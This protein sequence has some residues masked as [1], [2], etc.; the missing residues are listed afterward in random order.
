MIPLLIQL[1]ASAAGEVLGD[2]IYALLTYNDTSRAV[3]VQYAAGSGGKL[4]LDGYNAE[5]NELFLL[6]NRGGGYVTLSPYHAQSCYITTGAL[7]S[8]LT[9]QSGSSDSAQ[10]QWKVIANSDGTYTFQSKADGRVMDV[11]HGSTDVG[12]RVLSYTKNGFS[13]AQSFRVSCLSTVSGRTAPAIR[14]SVS[15]GYY[16]L[17]LSADRSKCVN[18]QYAS[19]VSDQAAC[20]VDTYNGE[21]NEL[22]RIVP[23]GNNL[24]TIHPKHAEQLCLNAQ[25]ANPIPGY[26]ITLHTYRAGDEASLWELYQVG[27]AY[28]FRNYKTKLM[29]DD[30]CNGTQDGNRIIA[31]SYNG[32]SAQTFYLASPS[33]SG[34]P[35]GSSPVSSR[36]QA[37]ASAALSFLGSTGYNGYCQKFVRVVGQR[38][39]LPAGNAPSALAACNMWRVSTSMDN[40]PVGAAVYLRSKNTSSAGYTYGHVGIYIG[41]GYVVHAQSTVKKQTLSSMLS[42]YQYLGWGWQAGVDLR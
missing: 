30:Y 19:T 18:V 42:S 15:E 35:G 13:A 3:N 29:L 10:V 8:Q 7:D 34:T 31:W 40:I 32:D 25:L 23:R 11:A 33:G 37:M 39:G 17:L 5:H 12:N 41:D 1:P 24:Y 2:G 22:F 16:A 28:S 4:V 36:Q 9:I 27:D 20:V 14:A 26:P 6:K 38:I 21:S